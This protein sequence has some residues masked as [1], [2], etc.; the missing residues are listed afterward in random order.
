M[1]KYKMKIQR[2]ILTINIMLQDIAKKYF[3]VEF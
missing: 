1:E 3:S 2:T